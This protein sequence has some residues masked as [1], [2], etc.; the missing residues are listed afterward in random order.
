MKYNQYIQYIMWYYLLMAYSLDFT[1]FQVQVS[2]QEE[3][4]W[5]TCSSSNF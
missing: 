3:I 1:K 5:V 2:Q 4:L